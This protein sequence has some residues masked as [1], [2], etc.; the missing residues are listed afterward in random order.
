MSALLALGDGAQAVAGQGPRLEPKWLRLIP[1]HNVN[2]FIKSFF[3]CQ[4]HYF[5]GTL[6]DPAAVWTKAT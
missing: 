3:F 4:G 2:N 5:T 1:R 6:A